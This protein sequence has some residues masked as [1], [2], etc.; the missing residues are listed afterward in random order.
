MVKGGP[1]LARLLPTEI[2]GTI[3]LG[4]LFGSWKYGSWVAIYRH[5]F[6]GKT[7]AYCL[8]FATIDIVE[9][10]AGGLFQGQHPRRK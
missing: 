9:S 3:V 10:L 8:V 6:L 5:P 2:Q 1:R 7:G 4:I